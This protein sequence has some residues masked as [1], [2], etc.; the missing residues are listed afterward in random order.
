MLK[1][2]PYKSCDAEIINSWIQD[3]EVFLKWGGDHFGEFPISARIIDDK[4]R[5]D[6]GDCTES[7]NFYPWIAFDDENGVVGHFI[8][9]Y[10]HGDKQLLRFGWVIV[11]NSIRG[12]GYG[13]RMLQIGLKYAFEILGVDKVT[14]GVF[15]NNELAHNCYLNVGFKDRETVKGEPWNIIEMEISKSDYAQTLKCN[16]LSERKRGCFCETCSCGHT[17]RNH[18]RKLYHF[19]EFIKN[20]TGII[21]VA[22]K[23][24]VE[25][26]YVQHDDGLQTN[27]CID[28]TV[29]SA[30]ERGYN[31]IVPK[32]TNSTFDNDYMNAETIAIMEKQ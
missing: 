21:D 1:L 8:M 23:K 16:Q 25:V 24:G 7:D 3:K 4:Y 2:R 17:K 31:V 10:L 12:K 29:K 26:I 27:F 30:F 6:N 15:E 32:G 5:L 14:I 22:R 28:A 19:D 18:G 20:V 13:I 9:R 11:D